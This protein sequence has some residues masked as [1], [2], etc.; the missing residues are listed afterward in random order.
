MCG[1]C[2]I[3]G[4]I[5]AIATYLLILVLLFSLKNDVN[6]YVFSLIILILLGISVMFCPMKCGC[7]CCSSGTCMAEKKPAKKKR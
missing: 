2:W 4:I 6:I 5:S 1:Q 7:Q 3:K